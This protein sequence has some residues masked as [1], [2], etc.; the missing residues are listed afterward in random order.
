MRLTRF[1]AMRRRPRF[2]GLRSLIVFA[3]LLIVA[4]SSARAE[5]RYTL[6]QDGNVE[7]LS[8]GLFGVQDL[9]HRFNLYGN[10][11]LLGRDQGVTGNVLSD[12]AVEVWLSPE[13]VRAIVDI[14]VD[15]GLIEFG[16]DVSRH[17]WEQLYDKPEDGEP[18]VIIASSSIAGLELRVS[19]ESYDGPRRKELQPFA[20]TVAIREPR[21]TAK[22]YR[23]RRQA[24]HIPNNEPATYFEAEALVH[25]FD[26]LEGLVY[27]R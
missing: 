12:S 27:G 19:L 21:Y 22:Q 7:I 24:G 6:S 8:V 15:G 26:H 9:T 20:H 2:H 1:S 25:L 16:P 3:I 23:E 4:V 18:E 11:R 5:R 17:R 10:G 13:E 14:V